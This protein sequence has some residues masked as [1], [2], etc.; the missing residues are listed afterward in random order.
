[1]DSAEYQLLAE[2][3]VA[4]MLGVSVSK[5][6]HDR[7]HRRGIPFIRLGRTI[8]YRLSDVC[9]YIDALRKN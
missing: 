8:R 3:T 6:Q 9:A 1:M 2:G 5:L 7:C 4:K